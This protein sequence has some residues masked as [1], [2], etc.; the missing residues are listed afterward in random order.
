MRMHTLAPA[1][2]ELA[3]ARAEVSQARA[4]LV[5]EARGREQLEDE[6]DVAGVVADEV[7]DQLRRRRLGW[8]GHEVEAGSGDDLA[9][10]VV[11]GPRAVGEQDGAGVAWHTDL[12]GLGGRPGGAGGTAM[13]GQPAG[14]AVLPRMTRAPGEVDE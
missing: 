1:A 12:H 3:H 10:H 5:V 11:V 14:A 8:P 13:T 4:E 7:L 9:L 2:R 6:G